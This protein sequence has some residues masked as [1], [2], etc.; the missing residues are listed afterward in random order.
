MIFIML[1][2]PKSE[3]MSGDKEVSWLHAIIMATV[4]FEGHLMRSFKMQHHAKCILISFSVRWGRLNGSVNVE[5]IRLGQ[6]GAGVFIKFWHSPSFTALPNNFPFMKSNFYFHN[7]DLTENWVHTSKSLW[8][9]ITNSGLRI[10]RVIQRMRNWNSFI[11]FS[12]CVYS[13]L[14]DRKGVFL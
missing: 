5:W 12:N 2:D 9:Q 13:E 6:A 1:R 7:L 14:S 4:V 8:I 11:S 3:M 10:G